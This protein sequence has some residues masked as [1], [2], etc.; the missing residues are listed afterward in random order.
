MLIEIHDKILE[1]YSH[2]QIGYLVAEVNINKFDPFVEKLKEG[3]SKH[4]QDQQVNSTN[5]IL[6]PSISL[7]RKIY[8]EDFLVKTK[9]YPSSIE[10]L[11]RRVLSGKTLWNI[12]N[13][14]DLYNCCSILTLS[15]MGGYDLGKIKGNV[16][17]RYAEKGELFLGL[18]EREEIQTQP[19]HVIYA[20][21]EKVMCWLW[22]H[23]DAVATC[24][25]NESKS[26]LFFIDGFDNESVLESLQLLSMLLKNIQCVTTQMG[27]LN[28][29]SPKADVN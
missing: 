9:T 24:I 19:N 20:D 6:H 28:Q 26:I 12:C 13:V 23:K 14:V 22:N 16:Q 1:K 25:D 10:A 5:Y 2:V 21:Q 3:L 8:E 4:L 15:P 27:I 17:I 18:G 29:T 7:W 11:L